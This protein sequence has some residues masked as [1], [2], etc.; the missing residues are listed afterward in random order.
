MKIQSNRLKFCTPKQAKFHLD[1]TVLTRFLERE[2]GFPSHQNSG[3]LSKERVKLRRKEGQ[4]H[5]DETQ[6][7]QSKRL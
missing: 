1:E 3:F 2:N 6:S 4:F 7:R 5:L